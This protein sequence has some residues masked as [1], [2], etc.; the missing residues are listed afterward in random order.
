MCCIGMFS[1][2]CGLLLGAGLF[3]AFTASHRLECSTSANSTILDLNLN[4]TEITSSQLPFGE[5]ESAIH[6]R[7][8]IEITDIEIKIIIIISYYDVNFRSSSG[9]GRTRPRKMIF[10]ANCI[11]HTGGIL[12]GY[13]RNMCAIR[14]A[15][16]QR[17]HRHRY[18]KT[19]IFLFK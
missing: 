2:M 6:A 12:G 7:V 10:I 9:P 4:V 17:A 3:G 13:F 5:P 8:L 1:E 14:P 18:Q 19:F 11:S 16:R 15:R